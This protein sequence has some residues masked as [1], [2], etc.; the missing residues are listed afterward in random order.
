MLLSRLRKLADT[1]LNDGSWYGSQLSAENSFQA[2]M[3]SVR[4]TGNWGRN[5]DYSRCADHEVI[6]ETPF[7]DGRRPRP[8]LL[9]RLLCS[10][11]A[12]H[13]STAA[14]NTLL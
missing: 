13:V 5:G 10:A 9:H 3:S 6:P 11:A 14:V 2:L 7:P 8:F 12:N 1:F 4:L